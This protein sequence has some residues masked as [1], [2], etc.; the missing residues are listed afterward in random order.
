MDSVAAIHLFGAGAAA[1]ASILAFAAFRHIQAESANLKGDPD[2]VEGTTLLRRLVSPIANQLRPSTQAELEL[3]QTQ[4]LTAGRRSRDAIHR[5]CEE[6]VLAMFAGMIGALLG[7]IVLG[8]LAG[9][10][11]AL[12]AVFVGLFGPSKLLALR[13]ADR[14]EAISRTLPTAVDLLTTCIDAGL[15]VEQAIRRVARE[16]ELAAPTLAEELR[17]TA[18]E[19]DAGV[20][21]P[22]ALRRLARRVGL[23]DLSA[24]CG[25]V[26]QASG[27]GAPI[28][29]TLREY[30]RSSRRKRMS[31][32][33]E[34]A[35]KLAAQLT[36]PLAVCLL[37]AAML[38][39]LG[40]AVVQLVRA[41]SG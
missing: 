35:G 15:S 28:S 26:A 17:I 7:A 22:D 34:R 24:L 32:L 18:S 10:L 21:L 38:I 12:I 9:L 4:L 33:E 25:V 14:R 11:I 5:Y 39:I 31:M 6:R 8:G 13:A 3:L 36:I 37:P 41:L 27:L 30:A 19:F 16:L 29:D 40:P 20:A 23:D 2:A 1:S